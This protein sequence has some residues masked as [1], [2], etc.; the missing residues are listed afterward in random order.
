[1]SAAA[2]AL[3]PL[4]IAVRGRG[5]ALAGQ[6]LVLVHRQAHRAAGLAP[7]EPGFEEDPVEPLLLGLVLDEAGARDDHRL[8]PCSDVPAFRHRR[9]GAQIL[10]P[11]I[12]AGADEDALYRT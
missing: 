8:H 3:S 12:G 9:G 10:D 2:L 4:E 11:S 5:A 7:F 6:Q 1:M